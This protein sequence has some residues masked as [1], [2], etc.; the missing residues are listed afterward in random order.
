MIILVQSN[1]Y[2]PFLKDPHKPNQDAHCEIYP[3][4]NRSDD[5]F[6]AVFDGHGPVGEHFSNYAKQNLPKLIATYLKQ[7]QVKSLKASNEKLPREERIPFNPKFFQPLTTQAHEGVCKRAHIE[8]NE[9]IIETQPLVNLSGSTA[10]SASF[11][12]GRVTICNVGDSRA[13]LGYRDANSEG[14]LLAVPL[15]QDQTPWRK[16]ERERIQSC[17][18]RC[19]TLDQVEGKEV[20]GDSADDDYD[21]K[22]GEQ[23]D[24]D[25]KGDPPR[26]CK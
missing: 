15:S 9:N 5:A 24:I 25:I 20:P 8:C 26:V 22:L 14:K 11:H 16:D 7:E 4:A 23:G 1:H 6:F 10:I 12:D 2:F 3:F 17:G 19:M 21:R 18:G 13:I